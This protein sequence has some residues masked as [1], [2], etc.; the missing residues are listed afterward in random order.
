VPLA[1]SMAVPFAAFGVLLLLWRAIPLHAT[2]P[3]GIDGS[4]VPHLGTTDLRLS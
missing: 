1:A 2:G 4:T 3:Y